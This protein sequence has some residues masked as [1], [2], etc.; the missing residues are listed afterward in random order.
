MQR[1]FTIPNPRLSL[2]IHLD[3]KYEVVQNQTQRVAF[4][5]LQI[6]LRVKNP[7][8]ELEM[9]PLR[10]EKIILNY[11]AKNQIFPQKPVKDLL[12]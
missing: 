1:E 7:L 12:P 2:L 3:L 11:V 5:F 8:R 9:F 10:G 4:H 6:N